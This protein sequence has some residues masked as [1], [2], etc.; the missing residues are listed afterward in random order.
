MDKDGFVTEI[1]RQ[2]VIVYSLI[3]QNGLLLVG[4]GSEGMIYQVNPAAMPSPRFG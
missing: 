4:T 3:Q 1:F 2:P